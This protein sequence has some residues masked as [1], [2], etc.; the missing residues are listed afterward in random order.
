MKRT[1]SQ[2]KSTLKGGGKETFHRRRQKNQRHKQCVATSH[3]RGPA[4]GPFIMWRAGYYSKYK[5]EE[6]W[7]GY[8]HYGLLQFLVG[9][10]YDTS[11]V[12]GAE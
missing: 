2:E 12:D 6:H 5:K 7:R 3:R 1:R 9:T 8:G 11:E 10:R 4:T